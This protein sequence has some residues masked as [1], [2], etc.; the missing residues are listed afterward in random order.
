[1]TKKDVGQEIRRI[2][3]NVLREK[4]GPFSDRFGVTQQ[5]VSSWERGEH[6]PDGET[7]M[8]ILELGK[9]LAIR[10]NH[11]ELDIF[12][13]GSGWDIKRED[14]VRMMTDI[15]DGPMVVKAGLH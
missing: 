5:N 2:R 4:Q 1:M 9:S 10:G 15:M 3:E 13:D 14:A 7:M 12:R 11:E 8:K 6:L